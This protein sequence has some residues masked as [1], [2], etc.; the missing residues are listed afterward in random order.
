MSLTIITHQSL[1]VGALLAL[2]SVFPKSQ[3]KSKDKYRRKSIPFYLN[4]KISMYY[5]MNANPG[6]TASSLIAHRSSDI[7]IELLKTT[8]KI[9]LK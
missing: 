9:H 6:S 3:L 1:Q 2:R 5:Y 8:I 4:I 7:N